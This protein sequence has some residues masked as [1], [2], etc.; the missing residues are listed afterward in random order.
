[1]GTAG[2]NNGVGGV[3][4]ARSDVELLAAHVAGDPTA[5]TMLVHRHHE[6]LW[7][8][9]RRTSYTNEDAADALQE[10]LLSAHRMAASFRADAA[11]RSWLHKIVVNACLDRIRRNRSRPTIPLPDG[12][13]LELADARDPM[14]TV[15]TSIEV[16][17]ALM[18]LAPEQRAAVVAVDMEGYS[19]AD[20]ARLLGV[21]AGTVKSRC[22]RG[23]LKLAV[24]LEYLRTDG[25]R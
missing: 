24:L 11:V 9:A 8:T 7:M 21:P 10:A 15:E 12:D 18:T 13:A 25:N 14:A 23:R 17:S 6:H 2:V 19:V 22:A 5:F 3:L 4:N 20:A 1:M 16:H